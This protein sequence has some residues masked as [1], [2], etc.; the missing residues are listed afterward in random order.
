MPS[1]FQEQ[2]MLLYIIAGLLVLLNVIG[3]GIWMRLGEKPAAPKL[4]D[5][6]DRPVVRRDAGAAYMESLKQKAPQ[7]PPGPTAQSYYG[8][9]PPANL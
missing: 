7:D 9:K 6:R 8:G 2:A 3:V 1:V 5:W 4:M